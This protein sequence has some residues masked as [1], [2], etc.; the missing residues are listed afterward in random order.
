MTSIRNSAKAI[1]I[2]N[3]E[4]L[5]SKVI[6]CDKKSIMYILPGGGQD[7]GE[8]LHEALKRECI[9]E[10]GAEIN[11]HNLALV[12]E[13]IG[14]NFFT[15]VGE[16]HQIEYMFQCDLKTRPDINK[17]T[18]DIAEE[19]GFEWV[20]ISKLETFNFYPKALVNIL[21][22]NENISSPVYLGKVE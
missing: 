16:L 17:A 7:W 18:S 2:E 21:Q 10:L 19:I 12:R 14:E 20:P 22:E 6:A 11:I 9:E 1:I 5:L 13:Y 4:I 8:T 3:H 15:T